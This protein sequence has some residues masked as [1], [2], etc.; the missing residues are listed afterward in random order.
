MKTINRHFKLL[1][2]ALLLLSVGRASA[3]KIDHIIFFGDS[4]SDSGNHF[5]ATHQVTTVPF[6]VTPPTASY[7]V[8]WF[9]FSN[10]P[11][12]AEQLSDRLHLFTSGAPSLLLPGFFT[13]YAVGRARARAGSA[14]FPQFDLSTQ[15]GKF[16]VHFH[17]HVPK[18]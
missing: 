10:G 4:L 6:D 16:L 7:L 2:F 17:G 15:V 9:H 11:T 12:W 3:Q 8:G 1:M 13:D 5:I 18:N 14:E